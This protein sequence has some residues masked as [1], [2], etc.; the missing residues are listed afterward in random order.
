M[1]KD[2]KRILAVAL[3]IVIVLAVVFIVKEGRP[4]KDPGARFTYTV[5]AIDEAG[6]TYVFT[7]DGPGLRWPVT[8]EGKSLAQLYGC[9]QCKGLFAANTGGMTTMCPACRSDEVG[10]YDPKFHEPVKAKRIRVERPPSS[11]KN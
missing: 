9:R 6:D 3:P 1:S 11:G 4:R 5:Y 7:F 2:L 8:Y 10:A